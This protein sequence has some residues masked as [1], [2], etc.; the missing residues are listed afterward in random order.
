LEPIQKN[1]TP[2]L[3]W[4]TLILG[5]A[6]VAFR[7][8]Y[9]G[10]VSAVFVERIQLIV[11]PLFIVALWSTRLGGVRVPR[12][13]LIL[14]AV[15]GVA[16][17]AYGY[18]LVP[19]VVQ[20]AFIFSRLQGDRDESTS[21][22][23]RERVEVLLKDGGDATLGSDRALQRYFKSFSSDNELRELFDD[24][25]SLKG[26]VWGDSEMVRISFRQRSPVAVV[27]FERAQVSRIAK[28]L[29][30]VDFVAVTAI[31]FSPAESTAFFVA[32]VFEALSATLEPHAHGRAARYWASR[33]A[34]LLAADAPQQYPS[35]AHRAY[36]LWR[37]GTNS[38]LMF[39]GSNATETG[40]LDCARVDLQR[41]LAMLIRRENPD[42]AAAILN[43][44]GV[45]AVLSSDVQ[46][47]PEW[48]SEAQR[49]LRDGERAG[50]LSPVNGESLR[51]FKV[52]RSNRALL[53]AR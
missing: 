49:Y 37:S 18:M 5:V 45:L 36:A 25:P 23:F 4:L 34:L 8:L 46:G 21:R 51:A 48:L 31:P 13:V 2:L 9:P 35:R 40:Y 7:L 12:L 47:D 27:D 24:D 10:A 43:N 3:L 29:Q 44:L 15:A 19:K 17:T 26:V 42:L 32:R 53:A 20:N 14:A 41:A 39:L 50:A 30:M 28:K 16:A 1:R 33:A 38:L 6:L 11:F 22:V 52:A